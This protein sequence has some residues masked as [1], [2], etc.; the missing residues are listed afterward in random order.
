M[1]TYPA[2]RIQSVTEI[3]GLYVVPRTENTVSDEIMR[4][5]CGNIQSIHNYH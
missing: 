5:G 4:A 2:L 1:V 3:R